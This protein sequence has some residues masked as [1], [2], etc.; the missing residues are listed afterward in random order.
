ML[1]YPLPSVVA[2]VGWLT[3]YGFADK[4]NA[5]VHPIEWSLAWLALGG[6]AFLIWARKEKSWPFG[7][8]V[9]REQFMEEQEAVLEPAA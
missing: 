9:I 7:P 4:A 1:L 2:A 6:V 5:G 8:K 3:I